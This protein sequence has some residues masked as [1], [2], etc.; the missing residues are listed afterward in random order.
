MGLRFDVKEP[1]VICTV[2]ITFGIRWAENA[3]PRYITGTLRTGPYAIKIPCD[4]F[5][6]LCTKSKARYDPTNSSI[7]IFII[8][9]TSLSSLISCQWPHQTSLSGPI[10]NFVGTLQANDGEEESRKT[11]MTEICHHKVIMNIHRPKP[12]DEAGNRRIKAEYR[13]FESF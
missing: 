12:S 13:P 4:T 2:S 3:W 7:P 11:L 1:Y 10:L 9:M 6:H 8:T 5:G